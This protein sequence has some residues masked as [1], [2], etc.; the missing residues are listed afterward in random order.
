M[1]LFSYIKLFF[2]K[3]SLIRRFSYVRSQY[4]TIVSNLTNLSRVFNTELAVA[5]GK[6]LFASEIEQLIFK[7]NYNLNR[8]D[9]AVSAVNEGH[10]IYAAVHADN[11][12]KDHAEISQEVS[13]FSTRIQRYLLDKSA[14]YSI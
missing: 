13:E 3:K 2:S 5:D 14:Q 10:Y 12:V 7:C 11:I 1:R 8:I 9:Q 4:D 6:V